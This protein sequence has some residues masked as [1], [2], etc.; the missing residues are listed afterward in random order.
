MPGCP[1]NHTDTSSGEWCQFSEL[2]TGREVGRTAQEANLWALACWSRQW[3]LRALWHLVQR[4]DSVSLAPSGQHARGLWFGECGEAGLLFQTKGHW[5]SR[6][7][8]KRLD[9]ASPNS[10]TEGSLGDWTKQQAPAVAFAVC[11][12]SV[13]TCADSCRPSKG[14]VG[15][16]VNLGI[17]GTHTHTYFCG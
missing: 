12:C 5:E 14:I 7:L 9:S 10:C 17:C 8:S 4:L 16:L 11:T 1:L 3:V 6:Q 13:C 15:L 2:C